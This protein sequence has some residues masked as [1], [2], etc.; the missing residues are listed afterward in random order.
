MKEATWKT[1]GR[2]EGNIKMDLKQIEWKGINWIYLAQA[3]DK[4][5]DVVNMVINLQVPQNAGN[6]ST[7]RKLLASQERPC[8]MELVS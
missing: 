5:W 8:S 3:R 1:Y 4:W 2:R 7:S 6:F